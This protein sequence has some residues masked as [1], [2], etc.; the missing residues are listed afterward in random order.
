MPR[1]PSP[2]LH[3]EQL[4]THRLERIPRI[5][6]AVRSRGWPYVIAW[7]Q[8]ITGL[9]LVLYVWIHIL[10]LTGLS[11][12]AGYDA[13]MKIF[14]FFPFLLLEWLLAVPVAFHA[15]NGGRL[16]LY[17]SFGN[18]RDE[19]A[20]RWSLTVSTTYVLF[21]GW[22]MAIGSQRVSDA[23]YWL[24]M[25]LIAAALGIAVYRRTR[26]APT[27]IG[28]KLQRITGAYLLVLA[29]AHMLFMHLHPDAGHNAQVV[30]E[31]MQGG[32]IKL[33]DFALVAGVLYHGAYGMISVAKDYLAPG[34]LSKAG[35]AAIV[36]VMA[37]FAWSGLRLLFIA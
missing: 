33:V 11:N 10:T 23:F 5:R 27:G 21:L 2:A 19:T 9:L 3:I 15:F 1:I 12:P 31:R 14:G 32:L 6:R 34:P 30:L 18:R 26:H 35:I 24:G 13:K 36:L 16:L 4:F 29:P 20:L 22:L 25:L 37:L 28:W 17:E 8:R 7:T